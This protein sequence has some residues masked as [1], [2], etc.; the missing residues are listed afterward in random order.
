MAKKAILFMAFGLF[1]F[2]G[3][4]QAITARVISKNNG[5]PIA[6]ASVK[7]GAHSGVISNDEGYFTIQNQNAPITI[8]CMGYQNRTLSVQQIQESNFTIELAD[9]VNQLSEVLISNKIPNA[10]SII[11]E[12]R[13]NISKNYDY[14]LNRHPIFRR[15]SEQTNFENLD[16][17]IEK[18]SH[19]S[20]TNIE[21]LNANMHTLSQ[22]IR[23]SDMVHFTDIKGELATFNLDS[24]KLS[25]QKA[26]KLLDYK[27]DLS[28]E[29]IQQ[30]AQNLVLTYLDTTKTYKLKSGI[31][32][33]EDSLSLTDEVLKENNKNEFEV[34]HL[35]N[36]TR[37]LLRHAQ[38]FE[39]SFL[40]KITD[41]NLYEFTFEDITQS[42]NEPT[43]IIQFEPRRGKSKH[44]GKIYVSHSTYAITRLDYGFYKNRHGSKLNL[45]LL[46]G[47]KYI[48]NVDEGTLL[49]EKNAQN[50]YHPK[51]IKQTTGS[52]FYVSRDLKLIENSTAKHKIG[53]TFKIEG[54]NTIKKEMLFSQNSKLS[55]SE[56]ANIE[57][58][59]KGEYQILSKFD[60]TLWESEDTLEPPEE[61]KAFEVND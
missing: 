52:Y 8:S 13:R 53:L 12:V 35:N 47:V 30:K 29:D 19:I 56:F 45:K 50:I 6:Y 60:K 23:E 2:S 25:V 33:I 17:E 51:Y 1:V 18:A 39:N 36:D 28:I 48:A 22:K 21:K 15:N 43:Y 4:A 57:Q 54:R 11:A 61:M 32:K 41:S 34:K 7:T 42:N 38:F 9:A 59:K 27:N 10:D 44:A 55:Q 14:D 26:T 46:L 3:F 5:G 40:N 58:T 49:F 37:H 24:S 16:F 31:F 20:K